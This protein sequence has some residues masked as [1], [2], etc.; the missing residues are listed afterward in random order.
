MKS[1]LKK[2]L[3][4]NLVLLL[5]GF[6]ALFNIVY[7]GKAVYMHHYSPGMPEFPWREFLLYNILLDWVVV[8]TYMTLI[9]ISTKK[10][11]NKNYSWVKII[12]I[13]TLF[14]ILIGLIIRLIF[15]VFGILVGQIDPSEYQLQESF[16]RFMAVIELNF[17]IYF[18]MIFIIYTYYY[19]KQVKEAE[20]RHSQLESQLVNTRMKMLSSQL[21]PHF[22]FNTLNSISV[23]ADL[24]A[25][26]AKDTI[27]DLS[28]F[29]R[30]I[31]YSNDENEITLEKELRTLEYYL[32]ILNI[33][34]S[35]HLKIRKDIGERLLNRK[36]PALILQP[37]IENSIKHGYSYEHTDLD[38]DISIHAEGDY[39]QIKVENN[40]EPIS[41]SE[42]QL[43]KKGVGMA[44]IKDRLENLYGNDFYFKMR[45]KEGRAGVETII[46]IPLK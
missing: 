22:L 33:R 25:G 9:A 43:Q 14:S 27:A 3:D 31:L 42:T 44:N 32:N 26:K 37:I 36:V 23:L 45:N 34:F 4:I 24:D 41:L 11:L 30:E 46:R 19:L 15:D 38:V 5:S 29:L 20:K 40:G 28:D 10:L 16:H 39:L 6:Y 18:A 13:H 7:V 21:Q 8:V 17:L 35:D 2:Y 1:F 12:S